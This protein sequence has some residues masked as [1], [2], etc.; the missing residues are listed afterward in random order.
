MERLL[1]AFPDRTR[2]T[3]QTRSR[4]PPSQKRRRRRPQLHVSVSQAEQRARKGGELQYERL[5]DPWLIPLFPALATHHVSHMQHDTFAFSRIYISDGFFPL[6]FFPST[7]SHLQLSM[8]DDFAFFFFSKSSSSCQ[9]H[10]R[11]NA[12]KTCHHYCPKSLQHRHD[13]SQKEKHDQSPP[14][15]P[16]SQPKETNRSRQ[17]LCAYIPM[18]FLL[19]IPHPQ[20][21]SLS[22]AFRFRPSARSRLF[23]RLCRRRRMRAGAAVMR[24]GGA[25]IGGIGGFLRVE[26]LRFDRWVGRLVRGKVLGL[27]TLII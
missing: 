27:C 26:G 23:R 2:R 18:L 12:S 17:K 22:R 3:P 5:L 13:I 6:L 4:S 25:R 19:Q 24:G 9:Q 15:P 16:P 21:R 14:T 10:S 11:L 20:L 8:F 1:T 7:L